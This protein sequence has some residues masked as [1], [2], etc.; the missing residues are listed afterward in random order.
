MLL[1][2][3]LASRCRGKAEREAVPVASGPGYSVCRMHG[4]RG[5]A[6]KV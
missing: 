1:H 3:R 4:P 2:M 5:G 6:P